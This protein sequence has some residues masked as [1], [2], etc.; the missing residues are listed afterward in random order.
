[1]KNFGERERDVNMIVIHS[2]A[3]YIEGEYCYDFLQRIGLSA[4]Y[5]ITP[6]GE[7]IHGVGHKYKAYHA[8]ESQWRGVSD[9]NENSVGIELLIEGDHNY[10]SFL[11]A[12]KRADSFTDEHYETCAKIC[13]D[14]M[15][16]YDIQKSNI[17]GH[18]QVSGPEV[19]DDPKKDPGAAFSMKR[20]KDLI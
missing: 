19:R 11:Q 2:M 4:H 6:K 16:I 5:F 15:N 1:M 8:G 17:V 10:A 18:S 9:L 3:E 14:L 13:R 12:I 20:L 7:V